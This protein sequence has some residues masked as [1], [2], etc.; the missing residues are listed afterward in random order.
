MWDNEDEYHTPSGW[1]TLPAS[2]LGLGC[3]AAAIFLICLWA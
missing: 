1:Y 3:W 2:T